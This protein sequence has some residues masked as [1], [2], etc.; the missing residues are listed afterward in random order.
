M[1]SFF[2]RQHRWG[3][4]DLLWLSLFRLWRRRWMRLRRSMRFFRRT[5]FRRRTRLRR[6]M[7][8]RTRRRRMRFRTRSRLC[9]RMSLCPRNCLCAGMR[10][11][12]R[13]R[14]C[15][16]MRLCARGCLRPRMRL[17]SRCRCVCPGSGRC[18]C[19]RL[20]PRFLCRPRPCTGSRRCCRPRRGSL[21]T[22]PQCAKL[23]PAAWRRPESAGGGIR[24]CV[25]C[26]VGPGGLDML[27]LVRG[28][29]CMPVVSGNL[30]LGGR[31][32]IDSVRTATVCDV[33]GIRD[34]VSFHNR[35]VHISV[36]DDRGV[37]AHDGRVVGERSV[38]PFAADESYPHV[39]EAVV[40]ATVVADVRSPIPV[41]KPVVPARPAPVRRGPQRT[42]IRGGNPCT[43]NPVI[44]I[45][46]V[47]PITRR[48]DQVRLGANRLF[49][50]RQRRR[51]KPDTDEHSRVRRRGDE[52]EKQSWQEPA[53]T[54]EQPHGNNLQALRT[55]RETKAR[56]R[57]L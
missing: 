21:T 18:R 12:A 29:W 5:R 23:A 28:R 46:A 26:L 27:L 44:A 25:C 9:S 57:A 6:S 38:P 37:H 56:V 53:R 11:C 8:F 54:T 51:S 22:P 35:T 40:H 16:C 47:C 1:R 15:S 19:T 13:G 31:R 45:G 30:F 4:V 3:R 20:G 24:L 49:I 48:P 41:M 14:L 2:A 10:L 33:T 36:C 43:R 7:S 39:P 34:R 50:D 42:L 55:P 52:D 17:G 32:M